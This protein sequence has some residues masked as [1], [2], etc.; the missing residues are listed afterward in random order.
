MKRLLML[1]AV[2]ELGAGWA[3]LCCPSAAVALLLGAPLD[4]AAAL[5]V[6]RVGGTGLLTLGVACWLAHYDEKSQAARGVVSAMVLYNLGA[7]AI[8][9]AAALSA[10]PVSVALWLTIVLHATMTVWCVASLWENQ[11]RRIMKPR[12][13]VVF[14]TCVPC[15]IKQFSKGAQP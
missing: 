14:A 10:Q 2:I 6:A 4:G 15:P 5:V 7:V 9:A 3:L 13:L 12:T 11:S 1:T 8:L